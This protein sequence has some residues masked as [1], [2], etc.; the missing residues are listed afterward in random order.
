MSEICDRLTEILLMILAAATNRN[1]CVLITPTFSFED[2]LEIIHETIGCV[3]VG[4][5]LTLAYKFSTAK[6]TAMT[7]SLCNNVDWEGLGT[8]TIA[9][10]KT[11]KDISMEI[12]V[13]P[14]NPL[15]RTYFVWTKFEL[16]NGIQWSEEA[17]MVQSEK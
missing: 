7:I 11:K 15:P 12:F 9:K 17:N 14:E 6:Q 5:K 16:G 3:G 8:D 4:H 10:M 2:A 13:L 1:Q